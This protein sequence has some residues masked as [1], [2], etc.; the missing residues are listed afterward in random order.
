M[1]LI[2]RDVFIRLLFLAL[3]AYGVQEVAFINK[4]FTMVNIGV[5]IF[6]T[7]AGFVKAD[8]NNWSLTPEQVISQI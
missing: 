6:V 2:Y 7:I 4:V 1:I 8:Y 3:L 5:I